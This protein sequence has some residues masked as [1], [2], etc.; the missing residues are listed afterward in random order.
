[1]QIFLWRACWHIGVA[2]SIALGRFDIDLNCTEF[3]IPGGSIEVFCDALRVG[4]SSDL[5]GP[6]GI[7]K[8]TATSLVYEASGSMAFQSTEKKMANIQVVL[9]SVY[10]CLPH[11][12]Y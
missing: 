11:Y 4:L 3:S 1:M 6:T 5:Q 2:N 7:L 8:E 12:L 10:R 9:Y